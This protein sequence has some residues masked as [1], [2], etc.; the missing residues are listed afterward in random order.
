MSLPK[1]SQRLC[2]AYHMV[3]NDRGITAAIPG[4]VPA[5]NLTKAC[6]ARKALTPLEGLGLLGVGGISNLLQR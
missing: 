6:V 1:T 4:C 5:K 2:P 3:P